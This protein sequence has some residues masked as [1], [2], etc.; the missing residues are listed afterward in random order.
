MGETEKLFTWAGKYADAIPELKL[1]YRVRSAGDEAVI[2]LPVFRQGR[3]ALYIALGSVSGS[4]EE[5]FAW[6]REAGCEART[7]R[8]FEDAREAIRHY[9]A[10]SP[11]FDLVNCE[12]ANR[13]FD[14]CAGYPEYDF[15]PCR[16]CESFAGRRKN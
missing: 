16:D 8:G 10:R 1:L 14:K 9:L 7:C 3:R 15:A 11:G 13:A 4:L 6:L 12:E 5:R 2:C